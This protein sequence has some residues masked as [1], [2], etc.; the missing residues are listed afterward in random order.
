MAKQPDKS[1]Q[2]KPETRPL[3]TILPAP[4]PDTNSFQKGI[5]PEELRKLQSG[6]K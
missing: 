1:K 3:P 5:T 4:K 2:P 6:Q